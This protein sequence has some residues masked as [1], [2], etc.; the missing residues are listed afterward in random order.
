MI[1]Q[2]FFDPRAW[3]QICSGIL[4]AAGKPQVWR[5]ISKEVLRPWHDFK[6]HRALLDAA[7]KS[8]NEDVQVRHLLS[9]HNLSP[10]ARCVPK[11]R[12]FD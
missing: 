2:F 12:L 5:R 8:W 10:G 9:Q 7:Y 6:L 1:P 11:S 3:T 4:T